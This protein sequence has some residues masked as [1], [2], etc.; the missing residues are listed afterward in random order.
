MPSASNGENK[1]METLSSFKNYTRMLHIAFVALSLYYLIFRN[2]VDSATATLGI[3][4][5]FDP[6]RQEQKWPDR[7]LLQ[8]LWLLLIVLLTMTGLICMFVS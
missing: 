7:P 4:L 1:H 6:F 3:S 5:A 2:D 8:K